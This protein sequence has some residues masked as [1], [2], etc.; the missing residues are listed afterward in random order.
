MLYEET[1]MPISRRGFLQAVGSA[2]IGAVAGTL[3]LP[4]HVAAA[5]QQPDAPWAIAATSPLLQKALENI[6]ALGCTFVLDATSFATVV[7]QPDLVGLHLQQ[8][9]R[10]SQRVGVDIFC[11]VD[12]NEGKLIGLQYMIGWSLEGSLEVSS[13]L[14]TPASLE[15]VFV[16]TKAGLSE[17]PG[18]HWA[19]V[20]AFSRPMEEIPPPPDPLPTEGWAPDVISP[21]HWFYSGKSA[22]EWSIVDGA[23][24]L[25][26]SG[27]AEVRS[28]DFTDVRHFQLIY[29]EP[30]YI[31]EPIEAIIVDNQ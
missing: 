27:V 19:N 4:N 24:I 26:C 9:S 1:G 25:R 6:Q 30:I 29:V 11:T 15:P 21:L 16:Q 28:S 20:W 17:Q 31:P 5:I 3:P 8:A 14:F 12:M 2:A 23:S 10:P 18:P 7:E 22:I 13:V